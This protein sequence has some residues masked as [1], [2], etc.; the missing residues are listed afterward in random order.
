MNQ[1]LATHSNSNNNK[2]H[3]DTHKII[4]FFCIAIMIFGIIIASVAGYNLY[5]NRLEEKQKQNLTKP[6]VFIEQM[7][8]SIKI[9]AKYD[10]GIESIIYTWNNENPYEIKQNGK[11]SIEKLIEL[12]D[13]EGENILTVEVVGVNGQTNK[14]TAT[15]NVEKNKNENI[16]KISWII[17]NNQNKIIVIASDETQLKNIEYQWNDEEPIIEEI[18]ETLKRAEF[19]IEIKRGQNKLVI[20]AEDNDGNIATKSGNFKGVKEPEVSAIKYGDIVEITITHDMGFKKVEFIVNDQIYIYDENYAGYNSLN[21]SLLYKA[22]LQEGENIIQVTAESLEEIDS[23]S[24]E[25]TKKIYKGKCEY[26]PV[27]DTNE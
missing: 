20:T 19:N 17:N 2:K 6:E 25:G 7:E 12:I 15:F 9:S 23:N 11:T 26:I 16:P 13:N 1:I 14:T 5:K 21:T 10:I 18:D 22:Q 3:I 8:E 4:V 24:K 27:T